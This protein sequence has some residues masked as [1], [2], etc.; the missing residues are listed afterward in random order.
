MIGVPGIVLFLGVAVDRLD[1]PV[2]GEMSQGLFVNRLAVILFPFG[3]WGVLAP[4]LS[5]A[6][7]RVARWAFVPLAVFA[8]IALGEFGWGTQF[9]EL[10]DSQRKVLLAAFL[11]IPYLGAA[12]YA[13][14]LVRKGRLQAKPTVLVGIVVAV[15]ISF[16]FQLGMENP[17]TAYAAHVKS[18]DLNYV[19]NDSQRAWGQEV[20]RL[21][22][23][24]D[25]ILIPITSDEIR[26]IT[27][28][29]VVVDCKYGPYGGPA[30]QEYKA[31][32]DSLGG[33]E[34]CR[35]E[36]MKSTT[37]TAEQ[38]TELAKRWGANYM[39]VDQGGYWRVGDLKQREGWTVLLEPQIPY[40]PY[41]SI[42]HPTN[43][44][45]KHL[46]YYLLKAPWA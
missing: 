3:F 4:F 10:V 44:Q 34:E 28:R 33:F 7:K 13:F 6:G 11:A 39:V 40:G 15:L 14:F 31:R 42:K 24:G 18:F 45:A 27:R 32:I 26:L 12:A 5:E 21:V 8:V 17:A 43:E 1:V 16:G 36:Y 20:E 30:W 41:D 35:K 23:A 9:W 37:F 38:M 2:L 46:R 25:Q 22:P 29:A 19:P